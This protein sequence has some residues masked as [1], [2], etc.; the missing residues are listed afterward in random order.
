MAQEPRINIDSSEQNGNHLDL[1]EL[2]LP[3][4][5]A[6]LIR[7]AFEEFEEVI[8]NLSPSCGLLFRGDHSTRRGKRGYFCLRASTWNVDMDGSTRLSD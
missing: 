8:M 2:T 6:F 4:E 7:F 5:A 1:K 3:E